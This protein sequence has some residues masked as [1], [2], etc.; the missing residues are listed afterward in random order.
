MASQIETAAF[1]IR[2]C[3]R[4]INLVEVRY[5]FHLW[6]I[7]IR[8]ISKNNKLNT[9]QRRPVTRRNPRFRQFR[10]Q[11]KR[12]SQSKKGRSVTYPL[13]FP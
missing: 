4:C 6:A 13:A 12:N 1:S 8:R 7:Q 9:A 10:L 3:E 11:A 5:S 2:A